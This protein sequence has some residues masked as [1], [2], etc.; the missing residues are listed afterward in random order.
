MSAGDLAVCFEEAQRVINGSVALDER[1]R[2]VASLEQ[3]A[4]AAEDKLVQ[5]ANETRAAFR[6]AQQVPGSL[7]K[8]PGVVCV[9]VRVL[10]SNS[11][12]AD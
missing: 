5:M 9:R 3:A 11:W 12:S 10:G 2:V 4:D 1:D 6:A 8:A 7:G